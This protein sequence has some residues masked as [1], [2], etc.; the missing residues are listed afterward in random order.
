M[1]VV[2]HSK[3]TCSAAVN[4][5]RTRC[6]GL[7]SLARWHL[8]SKVLDLCQHPPAPPPC[9]A[10]VFVQIPGGWAA[11]RWGGRRTLIVSFLSWSLAC[12]LTPGNAAN[13]GL[14][15]A[16]R[17][18]VGIAQGGVI[19]SIHT[20]LSQV[21]VLADRQ[22]GGLHCNVLPASSREFRILWVVRTFSVDSARCVESR[23]G[24]GS[25]RQNPG[26]RQSLGSFA[27]V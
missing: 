1:R 20:V 14:I 4:P 13:V 27:P 16:A 9:H 12:L 24:P 26:G 17:V 5:G 18:A 22:A 15:V 10:C 11:Q 7:Y 21:G 8:C 23:H 6:L 3:P 2:A 25:C 19:P